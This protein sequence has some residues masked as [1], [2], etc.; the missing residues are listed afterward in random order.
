MQKLIIMCG[1]S[2]SGK[3]TFTNSI[4]EDYIIVS[5]DEI[6]FQYIDQYGDKGNY[7]AYESTVVASFKESV[8]RLLL[9]G[10]NVIADA[11]FLTPKTRKEF[12]SAFL[13]GVG[14]VEV[15]AISMQTPLALCLERNAERKGLRQVPDEVI[16]NMYKRFMEPSTEEKFIDK[17]VKIYS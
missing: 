1:P 14:G 16:H 10:F 15:T 17:V 11:T 4:K 2:G 3:S 6:R 8:N 13:K 7:F 5:R 9:E 12:L